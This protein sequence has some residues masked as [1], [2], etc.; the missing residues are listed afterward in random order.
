MAPWRRIG[1]HT[2][3]SNKTTELPLGRSVVSLLRSHSQSEQIINSESVK[4]LK[5]FLYLDT[6]KKTGIINIQ[7]NL[8]NKSANQHNEEETEK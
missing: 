5:I 3:I 2:I 1:L 6:S 8:F 4:N 7:A